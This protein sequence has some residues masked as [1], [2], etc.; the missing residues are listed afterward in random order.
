[1]I[2]KCYVFAYV[3]PDTDGV[4]SSISYSYLKHA[5]TGEEYLPVVF[6][7]LNSE[8]LFVL[9][10]FDVAIPI[11][12]PE[13]LPD[14]KIVIVDTHHVNQLPANIPLRNVVEV[15]DHHPAG[16][17][18]AFPNAI[19]QNENVGAVATLVAEKIKANSLEPDSK[20]AGLLIA[21]IISNTLNFSAP[22][23]SERDKEALDW[24]KEF[25]HVDSA[26]AQELFNS[27]AETEQKSTRDVLLADYKEFSIGNL[28]FGISQIESMSLQSI[29]T[30]ADLLTTL[31]GIKTERNIDHVFLNGI[32]LIRKASVI[33][34]P[35]SKTQEIL[36]HAIKANFRDGF[37]QF[38]RILLRKTDL[39]P[40][41]QAL[42]SKG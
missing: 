21:A 36:S 40:Q 15:L 7:S 14:S 4:C 16:N 30:R 12:N 24:L 28:R 1:M 3:N 26:F 13:I 20:I 31:L 9:D 34:S 19:I 2:S 25:T 11:I 27:R 41:L 17:P 37:A 22:S 38:D 35:E 10:Y 8:T 5:T 6:G 39:I 42:L 18:A 23:T 33:V 32:D 29:I